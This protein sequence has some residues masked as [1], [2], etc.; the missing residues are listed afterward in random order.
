MNFAVTDSWLLLAYIHP[1]T[2]I[3]LPRNR[4]YVIHNKYDLPVLSTLPRSVAAALWFHFGRGYSH[5]T[6]Y[7]IFFK[8]NTETKNLLK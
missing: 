3:I 5:N 7:F 6:I 1:L 2:R 8:K 4:I